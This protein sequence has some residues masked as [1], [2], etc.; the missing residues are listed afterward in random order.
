MS[1]WHVKPLT[2]EQQIY[3]A[4]DVYVSHIRNNQ[5][6]CTISSVDGRVLI[7]NLFFRYHKL[8]ITS[9]HDVI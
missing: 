4:I 5:I 6:F 8:Y 3:A 9:S 2:A 1:Q 7:N